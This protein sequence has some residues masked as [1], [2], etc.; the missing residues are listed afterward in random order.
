METGKAD[1]RLA[2]L[3][4]AIEPLYS[5]GGENA[6]IWGCSARRARQVRSLDPISTRSGR[7]RNLS[8]AYPGVR[9]LG[10]R[11]GRSVFAD[12]GGR[13]RRTSARA[14][15]GSHDG[16]FATLAKNPQGGSAAVFHSAPNHRAESPLD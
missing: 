15:A 10:L 6:V 5:G 3:R 16:P 11:A 2:A 9:R 1:A 14:G 13:S 7:I 4:S 12:L 8:F